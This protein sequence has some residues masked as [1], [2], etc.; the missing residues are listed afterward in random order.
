MA[1]HTPNPAN[2]E[3]RVAIRESLPTILANLPQEWRGTTFKNSH[4]LG[5]EAFAAKF[6]E[7]ILTKRTAI[8]S[9]DLI[10]LGNAEDYLRVSSN[11]SCLLEMIMAAERETDISRV[12]TFASRTMPIIA[13]LLSA[14]RPVHLF[15]GESGQSPFSDEQLEKLRKY[16]CD[17]H[18][19]RSTVNRVGDEIILSAVPAD[20]I[21]NVVDA[22]VYSDFIC[23]RSIERVTPAQI[24]TMRKRTSTPMITPMA[25]IMLK[26][27]A[28]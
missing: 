20:E 26:N 21:S 5:R 7:L 22:I 4:L 10:A 27:M 11:M 9:E 14:T 23:L 28:K 17:F 25:E 12:F 24:L 15:V 6:K 1:N 18:V 3:F 13:V 8:T 16:N 2:E 19:H